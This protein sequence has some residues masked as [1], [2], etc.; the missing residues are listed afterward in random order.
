M[1][2]TDSANCSESDLIILDQALS[3]YLICSFIHL[4]QYPFLFILP[5]IAE[6][7]CDAQIGFGRW[8]VDLGV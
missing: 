6:H 5:F 4:G 7:D 1:L 2:V 3:F 8:G